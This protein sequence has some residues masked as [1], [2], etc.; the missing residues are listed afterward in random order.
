MAIGVP[1][2][3]KGQLLGSLFQIHFPRIKP[4]YKSQVRFSID[5]DVLF[6]ALARLKIDGLKSTRPTD[7]VTQVSQR[8]GPDP[9][10][11][12]ALFRNLEIISCFACPPAL[13]MRYPC[14]PGKNIRLHAII[15]RMAFHRRR[16]RRFPLDPNRGGGQKGCQAAKGNDGE[17]YWVRFHDLVRGRETGNNG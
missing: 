10:T 5:S 12:T 17:F 4:G 11:I 3:L 6:P 9:E 1:G 8:V 16:S 15:P 13:E 14:S 7:P 2:D